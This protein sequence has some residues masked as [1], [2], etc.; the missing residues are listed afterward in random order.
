MRREAPAAHRRRRSAFSPKQQREVGSALPEDPRSNRSAGGQTDRPPKPKL[1]ARP[2]PPPPPQRPPAAGRAP[3]APLARN[4]NGRATDPPPARPGTRAQWHRAHHPNF[5][6]PSRAAN[7]SAPSG[8][9]D[10]RARPAAEGGKGEGLGRGGG[11]ADWAMRAWHRPAPPPAAVRRERGAGVSMGNGNG[12]VPWV[13]FVSGICFF[14]IP[15]PVS[16]SWSS[17]KR[18]A[19]HPARPCCPPSY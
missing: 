15:V 5:G 3:L 2:P 13:C 12:V 8:A 9:G 11:D 14:W 1:G 10:W 19:E 17:R 18:V 4:G 6:A 7:G 16:S